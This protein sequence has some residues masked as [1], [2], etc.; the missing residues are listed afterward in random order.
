MVARR[1]R[2]HRRGRA[3]PGLRRTVHARPRDRH[4]LRR[5]AAGPPATSV[6]ELGG[7][8]VAALVG[9]RFTTHV[10]ELQELLW[11]ALR[12]GGAVLGPPPELVHVARPRP[13]VP[14]PT[15][16]LGA[17]TREAVLR[18]LERSG[19]VRETAWREL[20]LRN[21]YQLHRALKKFGI[22]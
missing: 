20:G 3:H 19:G 4:I 2:A 9:L 16:A 6:P 10:R 17:L 21:R 1:A 12:L 5:V 14:E 22:D 13:D 8:L 15:A 7:A 18:A 11:R